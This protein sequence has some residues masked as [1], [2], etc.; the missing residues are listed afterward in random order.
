[1]SRHTCGAIPANLRAMITRRT[2][3]ATAI[4]TIVHANAAYASDIMVMDARAAASLTPATKTAAVYMTIM[5]HGVAT[6]ALLKIATPAAGVAM[7][8]ESKIE[9]GVVRMREIVRLE[10][11]PHETATLAPGGNHIMLVDI[12][13]PLKE[14][15]QISIVLT[16]EKAGDMT[17]AVPVVGR[18]KL[19]AAAGH[20]HTQQ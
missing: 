12:T 1:M 7:V 8:H 17:I 2:L 15:D 16:F 13:T 3:L 10:L 14:G 4:V 9:D 5:N 19:P 11:Q 20:E 18:D 6:D